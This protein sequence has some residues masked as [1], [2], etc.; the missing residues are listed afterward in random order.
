LE[1]QHQVIKIKK[2]DFFDYEESPYVFGY[3]KR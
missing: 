1:N 2:G 3:I